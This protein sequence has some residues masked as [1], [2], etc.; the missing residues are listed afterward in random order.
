MFIY[1]QLSQ[2]TQLFIPNFT[3]PVHNVSSVQS[4]LFLVFPAAGLCNDCATAAKQTQPTS[5]RT[6]DSRRAPQADTLR[7][8]NIY[9]TS[10]DNRASHII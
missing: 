1:I 8:V 3:V 4:A 9:S 2:S 10:C 6:N 5:E 7:N